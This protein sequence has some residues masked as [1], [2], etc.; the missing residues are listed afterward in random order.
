MGHT[1]VQ[2]DWG[3][4]LRRSPTRFDLTQNASARIVPG[5]VMV[6]FKK[7]TVDTEQ[8]SGMMRVQ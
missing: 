4:A 8:A 3:G 6:G 2:A 7:Q 1:L 5:R